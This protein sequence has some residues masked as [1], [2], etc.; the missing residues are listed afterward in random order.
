MTDRNDLEVLLVHGAWHGSWCYEE[1][2]PRLERAGLAVRTVDLKSSGSPSG[3]AEDAALVKAA[4]AE[5]PVPT[6][7]VGHSY[8]GAVITAA[9]GA[10]EG[11]AHLV[12]L[13]AFM[14]SEDESLLS[15]VTDL[16]DWIVADEAA[17]TSTLT[18]IGEFLYGDCSPEVVA[19]AEARIQPQSLAALPSQWVLRDG[20][21]SRART[22]SASGTARSRS[23][24][25]RR[26]PPTRGPSSGSSPITCRC[27]RIRMR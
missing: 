15:I 14:L 10:T 20:A 9:S 3:L 24:P 23:R 19:A 1:L 21:T 6:V 2:V 12:Y 17:G 13:C 4:I 18:R 16:P 26:C 11:I 5:T 22:W 25:R 7:L 27:T 8:G